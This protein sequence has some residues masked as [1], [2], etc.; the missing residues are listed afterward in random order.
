MFRTKNVVKN[1]FNIFPV[2]GMYVRY[3]LE[4]ITFYLVKV[5]NTLATT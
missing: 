4:K 3:F 1:N 5:K 2:F